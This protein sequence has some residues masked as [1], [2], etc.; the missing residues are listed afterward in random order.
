MAS[1][2][3]DHSKEDAKRFAQEV[4]EA[5]KRSTDKDHEGYIPDYFIKGDDIL[6]GYQRYGIQ[7]GTKNVLSNKMHYH[8][9]FDRDTEIPMIQ[10]TCAEDIP[11]RKGAHH[12]RREFVETAMKPDDWV[13]HFRQGLKSCWESLKKPGVATASSQRTPS[14]SPSSSRRSPSSSRR[15]PSSSRRSPS[16]TG[17]AV[18]HSTTEKAIPCNFFAQGKCKRGNKCPYMHI[19]APRGG[20]SYRRRKSKR[21][22]KLRYRKNKGLTIKRTVNRTYHKS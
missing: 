16:P 8:F 14:P 21:T 5:W 19:T 1:A 22:Q 12:D 17:S 4:G 20:G 11:S 7:P 10:L 3:G 6:Y 18:T 13:E 9:F 2:A 15:S